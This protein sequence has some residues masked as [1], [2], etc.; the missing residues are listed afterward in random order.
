MLLS[1]YQ[2]QSLLPGS[3][4][5]CGRDHLFT[6]CTRCWQN[7][8]QFP[9]FAIVHR[10]LDPFTTMDGCTQYTLVSRTLCTIAEYHVDTSG[11]MKQTA[12][13]SRH[14]WYRQPEGIFNVLSE[15]RPLDSFLYCVLLCVVCM[16][17]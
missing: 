17:A 3:S 1:T 16:L 2:L 15:T 10:N 8:T 11:P 6:M 14:L 7:L 9:L 12:I 4:K 5:K 13:N